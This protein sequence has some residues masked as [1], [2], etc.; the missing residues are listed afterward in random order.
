M[1]TGAVL[2]LSANAA[3]AAVPQFI[4]D[5]VFAT[6]GYQLGVVVVLVYA[7]RSH[8]V[9]FSAAVYLSA[10]MPFLCIVLLVVGRVAVLDAAPVR[11][12]FCIHFHA[13]ILSY[14]L[15]ACPAPRT[16]LRISGFRVRMRGLHQH[17]AFA[18]QTAACILRFG[19]K[20]FRDAHAATFLTGSHFICL[21]VLRAA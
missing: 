21:R 7:Y 2:Q 16:L 5:V 10:V 13:Y 14:G 12:R 3:F 1:R 19:F 6:G 4:M 17:L 8:V 18:G 15:F 9:I 20:H 11:G